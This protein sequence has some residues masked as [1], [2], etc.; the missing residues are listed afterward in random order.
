MSARIAWDVSSEDITD[1]SEA[2]SLILETLNLVTVHG[3]RGISIW[4][5]PTGADRDDMVLR[6]DLDPEPGSE[7]I[8]SIEEIEALPEITVETLGAASVRWIPDNAIAVDPAIGGVDIKVMEDSSEDLVSIPAAEARVTI[9]EAIALAKEYVST[10]QRATQIPA[11][12]Q[13][14]D[15]IWSSLPPIQVSSSHETRTA[16]SSSGEAEPER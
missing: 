10:S 4:L 2:E 5:G 8:D 3:T 13:I 1:P 12:E 9:P 7:P 11:K 6:L 15:L 14:I 16:E